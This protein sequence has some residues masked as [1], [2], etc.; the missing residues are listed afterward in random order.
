M[1]CEYGTLNRSRIFV[2]WPGRVEVTLT[3]L[4]SNQSPNTWPWREGG[5]WR[6]RTAQNPDTGKPRNEP[7]SRLTQP[8][9]PLGW[10]GPWPVSRL[11]LGR[12]HCNTL[13]S[14]W[15][16]FPCFPKVILCPWLWLFTKDVDTFGEFSFF[17]NLSWRWRNMQMRCQ[18]LASIH[19]VLKQ[20]IYE[21][22]EFWLVSPS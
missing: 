18:K 6:V 11:I 1:V 3:E 16:F 21:Q 14:H 13:S 4:K 17:Y 12:G 8:H 15:P 19:L 9:H 10:E 5:N 2:K 22:V 7:E 20:V